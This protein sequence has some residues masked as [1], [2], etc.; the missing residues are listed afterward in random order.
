MYSSNYSRFCNDDTI[1]E[2]CTNGTGKIKIENLNIQKLI[3]IYG[4]PQID[5][6]HFRKLIYSNYYKQ[7][8]ENDSLNLEDGTQSADYFMQPFIHWNIIGKNNQIIAIIHIEFYNDLNYRERETSPSRNL[9]V[10]YFFSTDLVNDPNCEKHKKQLID[11]FIHLKPLLQENYPNLPSLAEIDFTLDYLQSEYVQ[12][13]V[14]AINKETF[15][16]LSIVLDFK[17]VE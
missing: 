4:K 5:P 9:D 17:E 7:C 3:D 14:R 13:F 1:N 12:W 10:D 11:D 16:K 8:L 6:I 2:W 15:N